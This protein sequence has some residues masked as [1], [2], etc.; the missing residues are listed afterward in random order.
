MFQKKVNLKAYIFPAEKNR[1]AWNLRWR[2]EERREG[3]FS[4]LGATIRRKAK[5]SWGCQSEFSGNRFRA[6]HLV[7]AL[8]LGGVKRAVSGSSQQRA[9]GNFR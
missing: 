5:V 1:L 2:L 8:M 7:P 9:F 6:N 4:P 3:T